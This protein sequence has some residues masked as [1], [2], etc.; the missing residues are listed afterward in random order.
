MYSE[1]TIFAPF[2]LRFGGANSCTGRARHWARQE[3]VHGAG[4]RGREF[5]CDA[6]DQVVC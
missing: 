1:Y 2:G 6:W 4:S 5:V 3:R